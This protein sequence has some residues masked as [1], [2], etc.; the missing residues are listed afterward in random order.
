MLYEADVKM[1]GKKQTADWEKILAN[2]MCNKELI[3]RPYKFFKFNSKK[4]KS[5]NP[6]RRTKDVNSNFTEE[7]AKKHMKRYS[8]SLIIQFSSVQFSPVQ[9]LSRV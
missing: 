1:V 9:S 6:I 2:Y 7:N 5:N 3:S 4:Y 8:T